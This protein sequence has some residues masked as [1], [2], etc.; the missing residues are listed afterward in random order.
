MSDPNTHDRPLNASQAST[1]GVVVDAQ[2]VAIQR[3]RRFIKLG[4]GAVPVSL[5][6]ASQPVMAWHCNTTSAWG[7][8]ILK[9]G[10]ASVQARAQDAEIQNTE[11]WT[12][13]NWCDNTV[14]G[15]VSSSRPWTFVANGFWPG[16]G[17][18]ETYARSN[19]TI[20]QILPSGLKN[21]AGTAKVKD[22]L[23]ANKDVFVGHMIVARL[24]A[25]FA[26]HRVAQCMIGGGVD[27]MQKMAQ[28]GP[29]VFKPNNSSGSPWTWPEIKRYLNENYIVTY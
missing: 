10:G 24:N 11:C 19:L 15:A 16:Q 26:G 2:A 21:V 12:V 5:T 3:R 27:M 28:E 29:G 25:L 7:S 20:A 9:N 23:I 14:R 4:A 8:A 6:L 17:K 13:A 1:P 22:T 18:S